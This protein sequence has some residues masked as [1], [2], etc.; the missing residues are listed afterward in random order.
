MAVPVATTRP[1]QY[2][3]LVPGIQFI[4][5]FNP[6]KLPCKTKA[7]WV[8]QFEHGDDIPRITITNT[9]GTLRLQK[10]GSLVD[11]RFSLIPPRPEVV[12]GDFWAS[13]DILQWDP[14]GM[15]Q[16]ASIG[17]RIQSYGH[18]GYWGVVNFNEWNLGQ[19]RLHLLAVGK[20]PVIGSTITLTRGEKFRLCFSG[21]GNVLSLRLYNLDNLEEPVTEVQM[22]DTA[23]SQ[24]SM[25]LAFG[26]DKETPSS[27]FT[28]DNFFVTGTK[29]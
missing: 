6:P 1:E 24:G 23:S 28:L 22:T 17:A 3:K 14:D 13:L 8:Q 5:D 25:Q 26:F 4:D 10:L 20:Q 2:F 29:P 7:E 21:V 15:N 18:I 11:G 19:G 9:N 16:A 12:V 27:A